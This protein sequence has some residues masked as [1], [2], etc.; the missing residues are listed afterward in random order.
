MK[1]NSFIILIIFPFFLSGQIIVNTNFHARSL[2]FEGNSLSNTNASLLLNSNYYPLKTYSLFTSNTYKLTYNNKSIAGKTT[3]EDTN[4]YPTKL[5]P[6]I[7]KGDILIFWE[8]SNEA[9]NLTTDTFGTQLYANVVAYCNQAKT[10]NPGIK[11]IVLTMIA[12]DYP[13]YDD[14]NTFARGQACNALIRANYA[15]F[16]DAVCDVALLTQFDT[17]ADAAN[18]TYYLAD[19]THLTAAGY[20]IIAT[21]VYNTI[22]TLLP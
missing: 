21:A 8:I 5:S 14:A 2:W 19:R 3:T 20:D 9:H 11:I 22:L 1:L 10:L 17:K 6:Y 12:R 7:K 16:C 13:A 15:S 4:E 18:A